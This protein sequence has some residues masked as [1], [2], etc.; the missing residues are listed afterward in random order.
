MKKLTSLKWAV[1]LVMV[2]FFIGCEKTNDTTRNP[3][4]DHTI[5]QGGYK[6]KSGLTQP[7]TNCVSCHGAD[8]RGG[9]TGVSCFECHGTKW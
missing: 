7:L 1:V 4:A 2:A 9:S 3:P 8:L 5:S 6:H